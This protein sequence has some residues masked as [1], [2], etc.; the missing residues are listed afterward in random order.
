MLEVC[1]LGG[2]YAPHRQGARPQFNFSFQ[3]ATGSIT[4]ITG[5]SGAGKSTLLALLSGQLPATQGQAYFNGIEFSALPA[6]QRPLSILFQQHNLF[7]HLNA[8]QNIALGIAPS[9]RLNAEVRRQAE[10]AAAAVGLSELL[11][12]LPSELSGGQQQ[13]VAIARCLAR[14]RPL[15][16]LDEPFSALDPALRHEM[17]LLIS[18]LAKEHNI[19]ILMVTHHLEEVAQLIDYHLDVVD[20]C[21]SAALSCNINIT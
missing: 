20:G 16:L 19:T 1:N 15:L 12:R 11:L 9:L 4:A 8:L 10:L 7:T 13:R 18:Q 3:L 5:A 2:N 21:A 14:K 17:L 6:H